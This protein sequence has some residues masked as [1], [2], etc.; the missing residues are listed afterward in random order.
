MPDR[1]HVLADVRQGLRFHLS[2]AH[3]VVTNRAP[4]PPPFVRADTRL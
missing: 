3:F 1:D 2:V 4:R